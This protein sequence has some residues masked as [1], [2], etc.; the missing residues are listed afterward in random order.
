M[1]DNMKMKMIVQ[2]NECGKQQNEV[3][4]EMMA[5]L[6][7]GDWSPIIV[8]CDCGHEMVLRMNVEIEG[9]VMSKDQFDNNDDYSRYLSDMD[10]PDWYKL[11]NC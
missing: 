5:I 8:K 6:G 3:N 4:V 7:Q 10:M 11:R 1:V 9:C 2:C